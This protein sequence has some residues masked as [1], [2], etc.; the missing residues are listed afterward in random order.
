M[1]RPQQIESLILVNSAGI[2]QSND[3]EVLERVQQGESPLRVAAPGDMQR[4]IDIAMFDPPFI[5]SQVFEEYEASQI[6]RVA[7]YDQVMAGMLETQDNLGPNMFARA[8]GAISAPSL[9]LWGEED[10]IFDVEV[11]R[12]LEG[13]LRHPTV[14]TLE[15]VGHTPMLEA[16]WRTARA[17]RQFLLDPAGGK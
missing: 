10:R 6:E 2:Y 15:R 13:H 14:V 17:I 1:F 5:P 9:V 12:E 8:L 16:P 7:V 4:V 11:T 3:S